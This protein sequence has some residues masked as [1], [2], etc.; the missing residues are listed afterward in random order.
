M[1][2]MAFELYCI[3]YIDA[4]QNFVYFGEQAKTD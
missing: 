3:V 2:Y 4:M 1:Y